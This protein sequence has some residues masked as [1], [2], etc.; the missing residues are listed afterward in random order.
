M[1]SLACEINADVMPNDLIFTE[2]DQK[3]AFPALFL[4]GTRFVLTFRIL[5][6]SLPNHLVQV[7]FLH[8]LRSGL[9]TVCFLALICASV[10]R[11]RRRF[12]SRAA[13]GMESVHYSRE[14]HSPSRFFMF[15]ED[16]CVIKYDEW[17]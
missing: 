6:R 13:V 1:T 12:Q 16:R 9:R 15:T 11:S 17:E 14:F 2:K 5:R 3:I 4:P 8:F 10:R 7:F